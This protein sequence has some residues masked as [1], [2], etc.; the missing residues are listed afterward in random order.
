MGLEENIGVDVGGEL[1]KHDVVS[2]RLSGM[3]FQ[4]RWSGY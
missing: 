2:D 3:G 1:S 4:V